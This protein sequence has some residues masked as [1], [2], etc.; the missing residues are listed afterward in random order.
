MKHYEFPVIEHIDQVRAVLADAKE[1][2]FAERDWGTVVNYVMAGTDTFPDIETESD[3]IR[4]ECRGIFFDKSGEV[5]SRPLHKFFNVNERDETQQN[6]VDLGKPHVILEKLDGSMIRPFYVGDSIRWA[7]KM[8]ITDVSMQ[9]EEFVAKHTNYQ[10][11]A[12]EALASGITP[13][14]EWCSRQQRI[15]IDYP[16]EQ[17]VLIAMRDIRTG[18]Y[19]SYDVLKDAGK[20]WNTPVVK[21]YAGTTDNMENLIAKT[22]A[23]E[24]QEGYIIRFDSGHMIKIKGDWYVRI[25]KTKDKLSFEKDVIEML[26]DEKLDDIKGFMLEDDRKR[27]EKFENE[28]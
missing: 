2:V 28:F 21:Q 19:M 5:I 12:Q 24:E 18:E 23:A 17:L 1:F 22:R 11:F 20:K 3:A 4:R 14:F 8:G 10:E 6:L 13:I 27:V 16:E 26:L 7:T 15:V 25:H 9:A